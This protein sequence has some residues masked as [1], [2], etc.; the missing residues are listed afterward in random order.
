LS[1]KI[2]KRYNRLTVI[3]EPG[4]KGTQEVQ[5]RRNASYY[6]VD[7][8]GEYGDY[9]FSHEYAYSVSTTDG[10]EHVTIRRKVKNQILGD[11]MGVDDSVTILSNIETGICPEY[12]E[13][14]SL[15]FCIHGDLLDFYAG[16]K[17]VCSLLDDTEDRIHFGTVRIVTNKESL[18]IRDISIDTDYYFWSRTGNAFMYRAQEAVPVGFNTSTCEDNFGRDLYDCLTRTGGPDPEC[19]ALQGLKQRM[20]LA[21]ASGAR[22]LRMILRAGYV[23]LIDESISEVDVCFAIHNTVQF[24]EQTPDVQNDPSLEIDANTYSSY[25]QEI[26]DLARERDLFIMPAVRDGAIGVWDELADYPSAWDEPCTLKDYDYMVDPNYLLDRIEDIVTPFTDEPALMAWEFFN[27]PPACYWIYESYDDYEP[28]YNRVEDFFIPCFKILSDEDIEDKYDFKNF[29][30]ADKHIQ[31]LGLWPFDYKGWHHPPEQ[32]KGGEG[33]NYDL[34]TT[35]SLQKYNDF[36][37]WHAY[38]QDGYID[39]YIEYNGNEIEYIY[40]SESVDTSINNY[41]IYGK[42]DESCPPILVGE[43]GAIY[44][45]RYQDG[46]HDRDHYD[47]CIFASYERIF[48]PDA[49]H[50]RK[51]TWKDKYGNDCDSVESDSELGGIE[52]LGFDASPEFLRQNQNYKLWKDWYEGITDVLHYRHEGQTDRKI[53]FCFWVL[54]NHP[55]PNAFDSYAMEDEEDGPVYDAAD[56]DAG[57]NITS[58]SPPDSDYWFSLYLNEKKNYPFYL[59]LFQK[60]WSMR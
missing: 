41:K 60:D 34:L 24:G 33:E 52:I 29:S 55:H 35:P 16:G 48:A 36:I 18:R 39:A 56:R 59:E 46:Y 49:S 32:G 10:F 37:D 27:E 53:G 28:D 12:G 58:F 13:F 26:F 40:G 7:L 11:P 30:L 1:K 22:M 4:D 57:G 3:Y 19:D 31:G 42:Y 51:W 44:D 17:L 2:L 45:I 23:E 8:A 50:V 25:L 6:G 20:D 9:D 21:N 38:G 5:L 54:S 14:I 15:R 47:S 43:I